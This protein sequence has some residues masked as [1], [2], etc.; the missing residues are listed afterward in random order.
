MRE[1]QRSFAAGAEV[2]LGCHLE[3][4]RRQRSSDE[5]RRIGRQ[6]EI[7]RRVRQ[8]A[9]PL[10]ETRR[11]RMIRDRALLLETARSPEEARE[12]FAEIRALGVEVVER[13][14]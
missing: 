14:A 1:V 2:C 11:W 3:A 7:A 13:P 6:H 12:L 9:E 4:E 10:R 8:A 5:D